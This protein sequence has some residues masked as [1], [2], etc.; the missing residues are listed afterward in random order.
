MGELVNQLL[1]FETVGQTC[2]HVGCGGSN[3]DESHA[4]IRKTSPS[5]NPR[6]ANSM[7]WQEMA[8][9]SQHIHSRYGTWWYKFTGLPKGHLIV[10]SKNWLASIC[11]Y[12][13]SNTQEIRS[14]T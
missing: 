7:K 4:T 9:C 2:S 6:C 3:V 14:L 1:G 10:H 5:T 8:C 13:M 11:L 12:H